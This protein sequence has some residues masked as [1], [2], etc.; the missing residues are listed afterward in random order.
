MFSKQ[1]ISAKVNTG[2]SIAGIIEQVGLYPGHPMSCV[3]HEVRLCVY[4]GFS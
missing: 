2:F 4:R 3:Q 1:D